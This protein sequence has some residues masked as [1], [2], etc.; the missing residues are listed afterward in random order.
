[1]EDVILVMP[2]DVEAIERLKIQLADAASRAGK[3]IVI[4][5]ESFN[6]T[7]KQ[8]R[9]LRDALDYVRAMNT[10]PVQFKNPY[11]YSQERTQW[12]F[13]NRLEK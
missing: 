5:I 6:R 1:M 13:R 2:N 11:V 9:Y 10:K 7:P 8:N 4:L 3:D 12:K